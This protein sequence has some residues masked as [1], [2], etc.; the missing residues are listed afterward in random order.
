MDSGPRVLAT[1][2]S[3]PARANSVARGAVVAIT[4]RGSDL[5]TAAAPQHVD[6]VRDALIDQLTATEL[7]MLAIIGDKVRGRQAALERKPAS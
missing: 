7:E 3:R 5:I 6:D 1:A 4:P 2:T